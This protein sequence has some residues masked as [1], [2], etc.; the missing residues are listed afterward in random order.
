VPSQAPVPTAKE[1]H[2][3]IISQRRA[4]HRLHLALTERVSAI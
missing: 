3:R 2:S 4:T 1:R